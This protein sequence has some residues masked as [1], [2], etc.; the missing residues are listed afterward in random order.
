MR[1]VIFLG[2]IGLTLSCRGGSKD[3]VEVSELT[4]E[5]VYERVAEAIT[6]RGEVFHAEVAVES[7][8]T[9][10]WEDQELWIDAAGDRARWIIDPPETY[11]ISD[12]AVYTQDSCNTQEECFETTGKD[13]DPP[14]LC[15]EANAAVSVL[16]Q[17]TYCGP[18]PFPAVDHRIET[19]DY[20]GTPAVVIVSESGF[21]L[22][23][24]AVT[25]SGRYYVQRDSFLPL[26]YELEYGSQDRAD[27]RTTVAG[28]FSNEFIQ[29]DS[30]PEDFF[31]P[32]AIG[33]DGS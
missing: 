4:V 10:P 20:S 13:R 15:P 16:L 23:G 31:D 25:F 27:E 5:Q 24:A 12:G 21:N 14:Q 26:G 18:F 19:N 11:L 28:V 17:F 3:A 1:R 9:D 2:L 8:G 30:L 6:Q 32:R 33:Y 29:M 7:Q 22:E